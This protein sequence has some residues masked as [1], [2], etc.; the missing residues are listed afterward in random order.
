MVPKIRN[1]IRDVAWFVGLAVGPPLLWTLCATSV[2]M[3]VSFI[4][5]SRLS[6]SPFYGW[7][8]ELPVIIGTTLL[9]Q[10]VLAWQYA[11]GPRRSLPIIGVAFGVLAIL[12]DVVFL[13]CAITPLVS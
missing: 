9:L 2:D 6:L 4:S 5:T 11:D 7:L 12:G 10:C 3:L 13:L 1:R 8:L